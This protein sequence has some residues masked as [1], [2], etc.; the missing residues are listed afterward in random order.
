MRTNETSLVTFCQTQQVSVI[1][2][3]RETAE[4][5][6]TLCYDKKIRKLK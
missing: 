4:Y 2:E 5:F 1:T 6:I 3:P